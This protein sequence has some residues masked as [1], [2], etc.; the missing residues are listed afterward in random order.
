MIIEV[1]TIE[2]P[3]R[4]LYSLTIPTKKAAS[5]WETAFVNLIS[6]KLPSCGQ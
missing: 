4:K 3:Y 6:L 1:V 2:V 5:F